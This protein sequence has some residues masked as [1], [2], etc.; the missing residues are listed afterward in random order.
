[1]KWIS[2]FLM[3]CGLSGV[4][5]AQDAVVISPTYMNVFYRGLE[6][7]VEIAVPG[8]PQEKVEARIDGEHKLSL[9]SDGSYIVVPNKNPR[10]PEANITVTVE[11]P[12]GTKKSLPPKT[13]RVKR[14][15]DP[16]V[17]W[18]GH[19]STDPYIRKPEVM[20][21]A[22]INVRMENFDFDLSIR[23]ASFTLGVERQGLFKYLQSDS[24]RITEDMKSALRLAQKGDRI[25]F[26]EVKTT[27]P[28]GT[29]R[30]L[31]PLLLTLTD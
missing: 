22:P 9:Q 3:S 1:M 11:L 28:D 25:W 27:M 5:F 19:S 24:N 17:N 20:A 21:F 15:P 26:G 8:V 29:E 31:A 18:L 23:V 6:N 13:F 10:I 4:V 12:D 30:E 16:K 2:L 14:I 7:P